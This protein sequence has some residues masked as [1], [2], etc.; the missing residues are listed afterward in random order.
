MKKKKIIIAIVCVLALWIAVA[1]VDYGRVHNFERP[2]FCVCTEP[3]QD[4]GS[5]KYVG[6]G[7]SFDIEGNFMPDTENPGV[8]KWTYRSFGIEL[9]TQMRD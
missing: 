4:G 2:I 8:T 6:L 1:I 7:Y 3:M 9:Q 5:G